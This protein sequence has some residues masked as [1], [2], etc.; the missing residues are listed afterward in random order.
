MG[1]NAILAAGTA[2]ANASIGGGRGGGGVGG[3]VLVTWLAAAA[4]TFQLDVDPVELLLSTEG[5][6]VSWSVTFHGLA[7]EA[8]HVI[9]PEVEV[10][11][12]EWRNS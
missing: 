7:A 3:A 9:I 1:L 6:C 11:V 4:V 5:L 2:A 12:V 10:D 8:A